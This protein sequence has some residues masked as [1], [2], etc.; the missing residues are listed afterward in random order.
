[1]AKLEI[2]TQP[3]T[4]RVQLKLWLENTLIRNASPAPSGAF[5]CP[6]SFLQFRF[7]ENEEGLSGGGGLCASQCNKNCHHH[8]HAVYYI[9]SLLNSIV[10]IRRALP[11]SDYPTPVKPAT[12]YKNSAFPCKKRC[13]F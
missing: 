12:E 7:I 8:R 5:S 3:K 4:H 1:L 13:D 2:K 10:T 6:R 11:E 9:Q